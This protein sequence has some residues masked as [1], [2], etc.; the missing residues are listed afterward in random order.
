MGWQQKGLE[1]RCVC[2]ACKYE[3]NA[4]MGTDSVIERDELRI[5]AKYMNFPNEEEDTGGER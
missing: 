4:C 5:W 1:S 2:P 3:C